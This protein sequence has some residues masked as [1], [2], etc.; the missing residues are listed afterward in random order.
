[1]R[2]RRSAL[3]GR[4]GRR[5]A[6]GLVLLMLA[7]GHAIW[8][9]RHLSVRGSDDKAFDQVLVSA[10]RSVTAIPDEAER[11][12][13]QSDRE[14]YLKAVLTDQQDLTF[15]M[16]LFMLRLIVTVTIGG[17]GMVLLTAA[18]TEWE[19]RSETSSPL[20]GLDRLEN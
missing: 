4:A 3:R 12:S 8:A 13:P 6:A 16:A 5:L 18:S 15:G 11:F 19:I 17:I 10:A 2:F 1:L 9:A 20:S 14:L 7:G